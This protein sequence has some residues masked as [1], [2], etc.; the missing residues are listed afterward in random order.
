MIFKKMKEEMD[1]DRSK[2]T[3]L[4]L[5]KFGLMQITRQRVRPEV[6]IITREEC[7]TCGGTG[8]ISASIIVADQIEEM[9]D[10]FLNKQNE[11]G[12]KLAVHPYLYA[13]LT[14]GIFSSV[15]IK[16]FRKY[17]KWVTIVEDSSLAITEFNFFN[18]SGEMIEV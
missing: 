10:Y 8:Q 13:Y 14:K 17:L 16:W 15:Q 5:S 1:D 3:I 6:N 7:P 9:L 18:K 2:H 4:P 11:K 12:V